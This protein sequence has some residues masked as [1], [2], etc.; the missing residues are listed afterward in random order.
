MND[1]NNIM[2]SNLLISSLVGDSISCFVSKFNNLFISVNIINASFPWIK[3]F[4]V[5][6]IVRVENLIFARNSV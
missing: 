4:P 3:S 6:K 1:L 2:S 5:V